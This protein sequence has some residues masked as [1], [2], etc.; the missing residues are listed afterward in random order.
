M[1]KSCTL[2]IFGAFVVGSLLW[3]CS[4]ACCTTNAQEIELS[5]S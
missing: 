3:I 2:S 5:G 1:Y 4:T